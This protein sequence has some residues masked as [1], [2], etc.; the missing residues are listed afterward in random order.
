MNI[1]EAFPSK[2]VKASDL[3]GSTAVVKI[4]TVKLEKIG[5]D[6]R[7]ILYFVGKDKGLV[8]N[9]SNKKKLV[10]LFGSETDE[11]TGQSVE[12]FTIMTEY[13][14]EP[15]DA[16]RLRSPRAAAPAGQRPAA[17]AFSDANPPPAEEVPF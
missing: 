7:A 17:A 15:V 9:K 13:Q 8:L 2:W 10:E 14:G 6:Q 4:A 16:I 11:W 5:E 3:K 1:E 12:L